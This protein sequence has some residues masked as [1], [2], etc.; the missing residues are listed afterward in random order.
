MKFSGLR[1]IDQ[2][3]LIKEAFDNLPCGI[4]YFNSKGIPVLCNKTM[5][6]I[7]EAV[8]GRGLQHI[9]DLESLYKEFHDKENVYSVQY[10]RDICIV[11]LEDSSWKIVRRQVEDGR[12]ET[13]H[14]FAAYDITELERR[15]Q[16]LREVN[17]KL[18]NSADEIRQLS[19]N[20]MW[21]TREEEILSLKMKVHDR[22]GR[23]LL[24]ARKTLEKDEDIEQA[25]SAI[26]EWERS[27][28]L[29]S[30]AS[31][32]EDDMDK[33]ED[34][35]ELMKACEGLIDIRMTGEMPKDKEKSYLIIC[36]MRQCITN[37]IRYA[38]AKELYVQ[39]YETEDDV[40]VNITN[41]GKPPEEEVQ[42]GGG[43]SSIRSS[44]IK[45][46]GTMEIMSEPR[47]M[48]SLRIPVGEE[49]G[50]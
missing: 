21:A 45:A 11:D 20:I 8:S 22:M 50:I 15:T 3:N 18:A 42:E 32:D 44:V 36:A 29:L 26:R 5:S 19:E 25:D 10:T 9:S 31:D 49:Y 48:L 4:C 35:A 12:N 41:D 27:I 37:A 13:F 33:D 47:F 24:I 6:R 43:L 38:N 17:E 14:E 40:C 23:S 2:G 46:G 30:R 28:R 7:Y 16:E 34:L 1:R 39:L